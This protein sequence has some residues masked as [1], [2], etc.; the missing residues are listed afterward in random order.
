MER[1]TGAVAILITASSPAEGEKLAEAL[2]AEKL[3][4]CVNRL[5]GVSSVYWWEGRVER[6]SE[7]LLIA[8]TRGELA[9]K[10]VARVKALHSYTVP[11][12]VA[13][14]IVA[15]NPDYLKWIDEVTGG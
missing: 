8:K 13:L 4:A 14:P 7:V 9:G 1:P 6:A 3:V 10:V 2:V 12:V 15:G 11:E 5:E